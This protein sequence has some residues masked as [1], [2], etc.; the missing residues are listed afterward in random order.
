MTYRNPLQS[1]AQVAT[2]TAPP[3][4]LVLMLYDG[5]VRFLNAALQGFEKDDPLEF[6]QTISNNILRA[7]AIIN[8]LDLS[9]NVQEGGQFAQTLRGLYQYFDRLL[10]ESNSR[11]DPAG[12][13]EVLSRI[14]VLR[15]A[16]D[17]MLAKSGDPTGVAPADQRPIV[18]TLEAKG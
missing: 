9:L 15:E 16:W 2:R 10:Q 4:Q 3:G 11:K 18:T 7:Q 13:R 6:H 12:I 1:Y 8:E 17:E 5:S 14:S